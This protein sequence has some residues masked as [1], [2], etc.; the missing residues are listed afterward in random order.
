[1]DDPIAL[2]KERLAKA[3]AK[4]ARAEKVWEAAKVETAEFRTALKVMMEITGE[5]ATQT[6][7]TPSANVAE[8]QLTIVRLLRV[9][10]AVGAAPADIYEMYKLLATEEISIDTFRTTIWRMKDVDFCDGADLWLVKGDNGRY[11]KVPGTFETRQRHEQ[12]VAVFAEAN[13]AKAFADA[14]DD[15]TPF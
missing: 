6:A 12:S 1:M 9:G 15:D 10:D 8:R 3:E 4:E 14:D 2:I 13:R 7:T 5:S 11:W